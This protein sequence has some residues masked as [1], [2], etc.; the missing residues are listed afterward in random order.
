MTPRR[1]FQTACAV[2]LTSISLIFSPVWAATVSGD[3]AKWYPVTLDFEGPRASEMD[4]SPNPFLDYRL[5][6]TL[7]APSGATTIV[8][9][10]FAGDGDGGGTGSVWRV[11]FSPNEV[12][13]WRYNAELRQGSDVAISLDQNAGSQAELPGASGEFSISN[14]RADAPG[15]L[16]QG[17]LNYV[18]KHYL[19][20]DDGSYWLKGGTDSPENLLGYVGFDGTMSQGGINANFLHDYANHERDWN[21]NDPLFQSSQ[22]GADSRGLIGALNYLNSVGVNSVYFL[23]MNLGG[24]GQDTYP[25]VGA[26]NNSFDKTHYD[27]SKLN[28]WNEVFDHAQRKG[29]FLHFVLSET[30][31][32][33]ERWFDN[34]NL[35]T[36][37]KLFY[38]ELV[39]RFGYVMAGKWNLGEEN[40]FSVAKLR[41]QASYIKAIDWSNKPITV[42]TQ[43]NDFRDYVQIV[44]DPLFTATSIQYDWEFAGEFVERWRRESTESGHPWVLDMDENT[45]GRLFQRWA[46]RMVLRV[47]PT[48]YGRGRNRWRFPPARTHLELHHLRSSVHGKRAAVLGD[49]SS[50]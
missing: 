21:N 31:P 14:R 12:G 2:A 15:F 25:F 22:S 45:G 32:D 24:D 3:G 11:R 33:N 13:Q 4:R 8:P 34:G 27:I 5:N 18:G 37:R 36:E 43:I 41:E 42:H 7:T 48:P 38:R 30:E 6:V 47:S 26:N 16:S 29:I 10:F 50:G 44:G 20:F 35:G 39:A 23:P 19:K 28:Q 49:G 17:R 9:G 46:N 40:D 1:L